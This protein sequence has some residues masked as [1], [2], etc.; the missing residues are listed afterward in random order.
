MKAWFLPKNLHH[1][2]FRSNIRPNL[3]P[4]AKF[5]GGM[6]TFSW[7]NGTPKCLESSAGF[8]TFV[9][10]QPDE[11]HSR[12]LTP[13]FCHC[14]A[15]AWNLSACVSSEDSLSLTSSSGPSST[16]SYCRKETGIHNR[17]TKTRMIRGSKCSQGELWY[18]LCSDTPTLQ[19]LILT[20][21]SKIKTF[22]SSWRSLNL[23][24][25]NVF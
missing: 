20:Y 21:F 5:I 7:R 19:R 10:N 22:G 12:K 2:G 9:I 6:V 14:S 23:M 16:S 8:L 1:S 15:S 13:V 25:K 11:Q 24:P 18:L 17:H 3:Q 4:V